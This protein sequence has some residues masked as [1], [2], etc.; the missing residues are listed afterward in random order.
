VRSSKGA[1]SFTGTGD[2]LASMLLAQTE[3]HPE[4]FGKAVSNAVNILQAVLKN[5]RDDP[6]LGEKEI[7]LIRSK[8]VIEEPPQVLTYENV[9]RE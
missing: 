2:L 4:D 1:T 6:L 9:N 7:Q 3:E 5:S 8:K